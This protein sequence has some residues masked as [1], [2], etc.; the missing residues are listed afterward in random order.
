M[1]GVMIS[2]KECFWYSTGAARLSFRSEMV[3]SL[4]VL[5][6]FFGYLVNLVG[7]QTSI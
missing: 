4:Q 7:F 3:T 2:E 6:H 5:P 1:E